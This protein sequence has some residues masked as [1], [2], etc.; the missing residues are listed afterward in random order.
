VNLTINRRALDA[1]RGL[2]AVYVLDGHARWLRWAGHR[3]WLASSPSTWE[4]PL[5]YASALLRYGHE[6]VLVFFVLSDFFVHLR[7]AG[8]MAVSQTVSFSALRFYQRRWHR[9]GI[10]FLTALAPVV[11]DTEPRLLSS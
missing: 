3:E 6:A 9:L 5:G 7:G 11:S 2:L 8:Q 4:L 1:L 10:P